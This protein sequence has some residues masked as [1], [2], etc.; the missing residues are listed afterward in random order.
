MTPS[1]AASVWTDSS[2]WCSCHASTSACALRA[3]RCSWMF[4]PYVGSR[5]TSKLKCSCEHVYMYACELY[6]KLRN[7]TRC[8]TFIIYNI[9]Y[10]HKLQTD[11]QSNS[12]LK[13]QCGRSR[14]VHVVVA[15]LPLDQQVTTRQRHR[16]DPVRSA[17][18][19][20][21]HSHGTG[22]SAASESG[23]RT[24]LPDTHL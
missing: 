16:H 4:V 9:V 11:W 5:W 3:V 20:A 12:P 1:C 21:R 6:V 7:K 23:T 2:A 24:A 22:T 8:F 19:H 15:L 10:Q 18:Q 17:S 14:H 13:R